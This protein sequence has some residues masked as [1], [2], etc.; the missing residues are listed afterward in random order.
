MQFFERQLVLL[1]RADSC[2]G[3]FPVCNLEKCTL[4]TNPG[5]LEKTII[6]AYVQIRVGHGCVNGT[7]C[8]TKRKSQKLDNFYNNMSREARLPITDA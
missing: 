1:S 6:V 5:L 4:S 7:L 3:H 2:M 8:F